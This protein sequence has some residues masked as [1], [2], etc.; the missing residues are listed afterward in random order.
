MRLVFQSS[1]EPPGEDAMCHPTAPP[2]ARTAPIRHTDQSLSSPTPPSHANPAKTPAKRAITSRSRQ[3][4]P[5][6]RSPLPTNKAMP[7]ANPTSASKSIKSPSRYNHSSR[8]IPNTFATN[9][10]TSAYSTPKTGPRIRIH[11]EKQP[12]TAHREH[13]HDDCISISATPL[14]G[15]SNPAAW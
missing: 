2:S 11:R 1:P 15:V 7:P 10:L 13:W 14:I 8:R 4:P 9:R 5:P 6:Y 3:P 12:I